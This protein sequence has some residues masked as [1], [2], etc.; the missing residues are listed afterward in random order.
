MLFPKRIL[1]LVLNLCIPTILFCQIKITSPQNRA[2]Y[3]R[4]QEGFS[5][6]TISGTYEKQIDKIEARLIPVEAGQGEYVDWTVIKVLPLNGNFSTVMRVKQGW[7]SLELRGSLYGTLIE[8]TTRLERVGVGEVFVIAGQSNAQ[9][10][11]QIAGIGAT[12]DR[13]NCFG[14]ATNTDSGGD[15]YISLSPFSKLEA[16][17]RIAPR[18]MNGWCWGR[19]GD[20]L[21][22]KLNVPVMF[23]NA[24]FEGTSSSTWAISANGNNAPNPYIGGTYQNK[25]PYQDLSDSFHYFV[26]QLGIRAVLWC[27]GESD[28]FL[29]NQKLATNSEVYRSNLQT[30]IN[31]SRSDSGKDIS[32]VVSLTSG[33]S[34]TPCSG[35][36]GTPIVTDQNI[37]NGQLA[38]INQ[39][40]NNVF[41]GPNTDQIQVTGRQDGV[42]FN[43]VGLEQL[44]NAWS[45]ALNDN[46]F[47]NSRPQL[48]MTIGNLDFYCGNNQVDVNLPDGY[49]NYQWSNNGSNFSSGVF[50]SQKLTRLSVGTDKKYYA[51]FR[52]NVG[53]VIQVPYISF[54][55]SAVPSA[56]ITA[57]SDVSF[58]DGNSVTLNA[59]DAAIYEW[60]NGSIAKSINVSTS[61]S[62]AVRT[63]NQYGCQSDFSPTVTTTNK[64][65]P[66]K[67][68]IAAS[69]PTTFCADT[70]VT[71]T[72]SNTQAGSYLWSTGTNSQNLRI[73]TS[74]TYRV[75]TI[76]PQ[77]CSSPISDGIQIIVNPLPPTPTIVASG[78]TTFCADT[79][80][81]LTSSNVSANRYLW[82]TGTSTQ[83]IRINTSGDYTVRTID[84]NNCFSMASAAQKITVNP[85]PATPTILSTKD[86][87]FCDGDNTTLQMSLIAG[88]RPTWLASQ[89]GTVTNF[90]IQ[91][92]TI[93]QSGGFRAYQTDGNDCKSPISPTVF[94]SVKANPPRVDSI[95]RLSP[96]TVGVN[97][98]RADQYVWQVN[99]VANNNLSGSSIRF[100]EE[101]NLSV[102][103]KNVYPT[104][105]YGDKVCF[106]PVSNQYAF[107]FFNDNGVSIY[108]NPSNGVFKIEARDPWNNTT[109]EVYNLLGGLLQRG[110]ISSLDASRT[111]NLTDLP[112]GQYMLRLNTDSLLIT[113]RI[114]INR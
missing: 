26:A 62:F 72:S 77:G 65:L 112:E 79:D 21:V 63:V 14:S 88:N 102:I 84:G 55:G 4:N 5:Q 82:N 36:C 60:S 17:S 67:P 114:I 75:T 81:T 50:S 22:N 19:L 64:P 11:P 96:Y 3:Q 18:G 59:N 95:V 54:V 85:L 27:Q 25:L 105:F 103:A 107:K 44:A 39:A 45:N 57:S 41:F 99:G 30:I 23:F 70:D 31:K 110:T 20:L 35:I 100:T 90:G 51:R 34:A 113:K 29:V 61:G 42:H 69:G 104:L 1:L 8:G 89:N 56:S 92:L 78:P 80:V 58:C 73:N 91:N 74:G 38:V 111:M 53:N 28:N 106:S 24:A 86:T 97:A 66:P 109:Y 101:A 9:G 32:W 15:F 37:I 12:N 71:L 49:S 98:V 93:T 43:G 46:F 13:V 6:I 2:V 87:V 68:T 16:N 94:V 52:D 40:N 83:N 33:G 7:Y 76:S 10:M 48:P 108:P 47:G